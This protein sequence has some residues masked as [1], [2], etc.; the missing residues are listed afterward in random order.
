MTVALP[1]ESA[2]WPIFRLL[3]RASF[4]SSGAGGAS[5]A[6]WTV[7]PMQSSKPDSSG[8]ILLSY[9]RCLLPQ[10]GTARILFRYGRFLGKMIGASAASSAALANGNPWDP[11]TDSLAIPDLTGQEIRIQAA[12]RGLDGENTS[13]AAWVTVFWGTCEYQ[14]DDGWGGADTPAGERTYHCVDALHRLKRWNLDCHGYYSSGT[15]ISNA[16]G[17]PGYNVAPGAPAQLAGNRESTGTTF[18]TQSGGTA[19]N[20]CRPGAGTT[21]TDKQAV[22]H[23]LAVGRPPGEPLFVLTGAT[24]LYSD[25]SAIDVPE[26]RTVF[27]LVSSVCSRGRGRGAVRLEWTEASPTGAITPLLKA[28]AQLAHAYTYTIPS[29]GGTGTVNGATENSTTVTVDLI[30][31]HRFLPSS[32]ILGDAQQ[33]QCDYMESVG[34]KIQTLATLS[35][36]DGTLEAGW[37]ASSKTAFNAITDPSKRTDIKWKPVYQ[38]HRLARSFD[39]TVKNGSGS[40]SSRCDFRCSDDGEVY[41]GG[42]VDTSVLTAKVMDD[43]PLYEGYV[44]DTVAARQDGS[45]VSSFAGTP[46][47]RDP[48]L[49]ARNSS[50][51]F[52]AVGGMGETVHLKISQDGFLVTASNNQET[53]LR[54]FADSDGVSV[55]RVY[56]YTQLGMT[57]GIELPHR[58]RLATGDPDGKRRMKIEHPDLHLW[59]AH[60]GAIWDYDSTNIVSGYSPAK[61]AAATSASGILRD[62]RDSLARLHFL[63]VAWYGPMDGIV[64]TNTRRSAQW[65]LRCCGDIPTSDSYDGGGV[66]YPDV[67]KVVTFMYANGQKL[68][69]MTPVS[70]Y[71]YDNEAGVSTW[72]TDW[73]DL[74]FVR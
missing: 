54:Y 13:S 63:S 4:G 35:Y 61:R 10:I 24:D 67:G 19:F 26:G 15:S 14:Q 43:L 22:D 70:S 34:E 8:F 46:A 36:Q 57:V 1:L 42:V 6:G 41:I 45:T 30:G 28:Y 62:D 66:V 68:S 50:G 39:F 53:G 56:D 3:T 27:D 59:V 33:Y 52:L 49:W 25:S 60:P 29:T 12:P 58:V 32:L 31:D 16:K 2:R 65:A 21:W 23:A 9:S 55:Q 74:D 47:R 38:L 71:V 18:T 5:G 48:L 40:S 72:T 69:L 51:N 37:I 7:Q 64:S 44:Y 11:T 73:S 17:H 20:H